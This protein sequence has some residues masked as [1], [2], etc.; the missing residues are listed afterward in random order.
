[1]HPRCESSTPVW[2]MPRSLS[3]LMRARTDRFAP[4]ALS[5]AAVQL[6]SFN[7]QCPQLV[8]GWLR[9]ATSDLRYMLSHF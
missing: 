4:Q 8:N 1:V 9:L 6:D 7:L 5:T 2:M 3:R